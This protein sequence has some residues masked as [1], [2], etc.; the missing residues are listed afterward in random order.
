MKKRKRKVKQRK[1]LPAPS[2]RELQEQMLRLERSVA[3]LHADVQR[4]FRSLATVEAS[5]ML[6]RGRAANIFDP[7]NTTATPHA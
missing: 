4:L 3:Y 1:R 5:E 2:M 6:S 7:A